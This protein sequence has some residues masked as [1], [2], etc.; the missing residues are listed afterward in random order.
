MNIEIK[1]NILKLIHYNCIPSDIDILIYSSGKAGGTTLFSTFNNNGYSCLYVH[2]I[3]SLKYNMYK[4]IERMSLR[5]QEYREQYDELH[6]QG[7]YQEKY[8][9]EHAY[10]Y[11]SDSE[12]DE[13]SDDYE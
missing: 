11:D 12:S 4:T 5:W 9:C 2:D 1:N 3:H 13:D 10:G 8:G 7:S 6:G